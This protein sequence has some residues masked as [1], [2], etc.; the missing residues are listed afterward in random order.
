MADDWAPPPPTG[1][2]G[3]DWIEI[4]SGE[5]LKGRIKSLQQEDLEFDSEELD[6][7]VW[8]WKDV[9]TLRSA[10]PFSVRLTNN[11]VIVGS[12]LVTRTEMQII[13]DS[14]TQTFPRAELLAITPAGKRIRDKWSVD[15]SA[16]F[17]TRSGNLSEVSNN[18]S[19]VLMREVPIARQRIEY[20]GN[21]GKLDGVVNKED[22]RWSGQSD[23]FISRRF[24]VRVPD[25]E[26]FHDPQQNLNYRITLGLSAGYDLILTPRTEWQIS[27][28]PAFQWNSF[29]L[30]EGDADSKAESK[31]LVVENR[32]ETEL[33]KRLDFICDYRGQ[34]AGSSGGGNM[35]HTVSTLEFEIHKRLT[36][37]FTL[38]WDRIA[39]PQTRE[40]GSTPDSDDLQFIT[41]LGIHF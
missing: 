1:N 36:L 21:Y 10:R 30:V 23:I 16:G 2:D 20:L 15:V 5:W 37:D 9:R 14:V 13:N 6:V 26:Y 27:I 18:T 29:D 41:S 8:D 35:H 33:T 34:F 11:L 24:F 39:E 28:G 19:L 32:F 25:F 4:K 3:F 31:A 40:D 12:L 17:S 22:Q 38:T 7:H